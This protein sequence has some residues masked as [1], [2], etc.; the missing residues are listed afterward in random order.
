MVG[1]AAACRAIG[2]NRATL[3]RR[4]SPKRAANPRPKPP[5]ALTE[6]EQQQVLEQLHSPRF[7]DRSVAETYATL[8]DEGLYLASISTMY[9]LLWGKRRDPRTA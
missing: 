7:V 3:Y 6:A 8:L 1:V 5:R 4:R 9:R 2:V